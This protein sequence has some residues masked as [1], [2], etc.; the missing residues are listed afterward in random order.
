LELQR[1]F[2]RVLPDF[3][4]TFC[5]LAV[6]FH[7]LALPVYAASSAR[8]AK[9]AGRKFMGNFYTDFICQDSRYDSVPRVG[10]PSLLEPIT[11]QLVESLITSARQMGIQVEIYETYRSQQRQQLLFDNGATKLRSVGVH[12]Y[13]LAC[14]IVRVVGGEPSWKGDFTFLGQLAHSSG[15]IWGGDWGDPNMKHSFVDSVHVQRC[16]VSRQGDLFA[17]NWYPGD[18]YNPYD[19]GQHLFADAVATAKQPL[20]AA[21]KT[22]G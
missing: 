20:K 22:A 3:C 14:D 21:G 13:G 18:G 6:N 5:L 4:W 15:L 16:T 8:L 7:P 17:G 9:I 1:Y 12:H 10:D 19:D 11:R 2:S